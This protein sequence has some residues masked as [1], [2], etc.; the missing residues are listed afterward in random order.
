MSESEIKSM[1]EKPKMES[2]SPAADQKKD[3]NEVKKAEEPEETPSVDEDLKDIEKAKQPEE[4]SSVDKKKDSQDVEKAGQP[5]KE[6]KSLA[7]R[8]EQAWKFAPNPLIFLKNVFVILLNTSMNML[9][10][11]DVVSKKFKNEL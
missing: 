6:Q 3:S 5:E 8:L 2:K 4:T 7:Q 11:Y 1:V 9:N 10:S